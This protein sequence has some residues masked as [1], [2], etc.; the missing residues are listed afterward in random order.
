VAASAPGLLGATISIA[1]SVLAD[2]DGVLAVAAANVA[3]GFV[4][5]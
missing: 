5:E 1:T 3:A 2:V 4:G